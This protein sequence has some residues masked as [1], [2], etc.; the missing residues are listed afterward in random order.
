[1]KI[2]VLT[3]HSTNID[4]NTYQ[5]NDL[6]AF[7]QDLELINALN[8]EII[9]THRLVAW[10][11]G[12]IELDESLNYVVLTFD[13]GCELDFWDWQHPIHG[14][15][16]SFYSS[17]KAYD[18]DIHA[19]SFV[20]ASKQARNTLAETCTAGFQIW[21]G[22]W[23]KKAEN[24]GLFSIENHSWDHL[25]TSL[26]TVNQQNNEKGDFTKII[27]L[28]DADSQIKEA[29]RYI[30][31]QINNKVTLF[32]YPYGHYNPY[33]TETYFANQQSSIKAA[34][35]CDANRVNQRTNIWSIPRYVCGQH[36]KS[37]AELEII[38]IG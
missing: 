16:Q 14:Q 23:W 12:E 15:Q 25:H 8:V 36:W 31:S 37:S 26:D 35:T 2:P 7:K 9:S 11:R 18:G 6:I 32:A 33:L 21:G 3:Y 29:T 24:T 28:D 38:L 27:T 19:T 5:R 13:D 10:V 1:M 22:G 20:I 30:N 34:F 17:M 4:G